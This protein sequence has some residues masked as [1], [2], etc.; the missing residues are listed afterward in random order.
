[1]R[2]RI[3]SILLSICFC[4]LGI[5]AQVAAQPSVEGILEKAVNRLGG[6]RYLK[7]RTQVGTGRFAIFKNGAVVS[8]Q[9]FYDV[10]VF[11]DRE[12]TEFK[13]GKVRYVQVNTGETGWV[14]DGEQDRVRDQTAE[15]IASFKNSIRASLD[16]LLRRGW[17]GRAVLE[18]VGK[19]P[20]S[21]GKRND[22]L[23][24]KYD[25][26]FTVEFEF[27]DDGTPQKAIYT[28][29][30]GDAETKEEDRYAQ[31]VDIQ[32]VKTPFIIDRFSNGS[33]TSR[34][35]YES[36]EFDRPVSD[37]IFTKPE[38]AREARKSMHL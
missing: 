20:A 8:F 34:I 30:D 9:S 31:W 2:R 15:Q 5:F 36:I 23:R 7:I 18:Y 12:R 27:A 14:Y 13:T 4:H 33:Q 32:G 35:N 37:K 3:V 21:L 22:V 17:A 16:N 6:E 1:M 11:P 25:D 29:P 26:G 19:R 24:L 28:R 10:I 38:S